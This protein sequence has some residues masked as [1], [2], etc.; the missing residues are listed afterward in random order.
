MTSHLNSYQPPSPPLDIPFECHLNTPPDRYDHNFSGGPVYTLSTDRLT[1]VPFV[2]SLHGKQYYHDIKEHGHLMKYMPYPRRMDESLDNLLFVYEKTIRSLPA[3]AGRTWAS[4]RMTTAES[5]LLL[6]G[7]L[8]VGTVR[9]D[10]SREYRGRGRRERVSLAP[11]SS[12]FEH[13][14]WGHGDARHG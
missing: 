11:R 10:K 9:P 1:L 3:S 4:C 7:L 5:S 14:C 13:L 2:P 6:A 12:A 8:L